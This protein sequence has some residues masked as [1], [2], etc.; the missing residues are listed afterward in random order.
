M[1]ILSFAKDY[2]KS[3]TGSNCGFEAASFLFMPIT[4]AKKEEVVKEL[5]E[6]IAK[7]NSL[8]LAKFHGLSVAKVSQLRR[9]FRAIGAEYTV[10][11][12]SLLAL[13]FK[14]SGK[15]IPGELRGEVAL[16]AGLL[17]QPADGGGDELD[18]FKVAVEFAKKEK[19]S[20]QLLGGFFPAKGGSA[21][22]GLGGELQWID[23]GIAISLGMIPSRDVL[24]AK[25][26]N[27]ILGNTRKFMYIVDQLSRKGHNLE[28]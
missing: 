7:A 15:E 24:I 25:L 22:G 21:S 4:R 23:A 5:K 18:I 20:F 9:K 19:E 17:R 26:M 13:A 6:K 2:Y 10:A 11:K 27:V 28:A 16:I 1:L 3:Y 12:K 8:A 14:E